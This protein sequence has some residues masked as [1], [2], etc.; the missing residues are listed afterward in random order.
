MGTPVVCSTKWGNLGL[1]ESTT[2]FM[3]IETSGGRGTD[4]AHS[5]AHDGF[6][7]THDGQ[8]QKLPRGPEGAGICRTYDPV[9]PSFYLSTFLPVVYHCRTT[10]VEQTS[11]DETRRPGKP[12]STV[13][14][15]VPRVCQEDLGVSVSE[16]NVVQVER[17]PETTLE[18]P[19][20]RGRT[21]VEKP[22]RRQIGPSPRKEYSSV[23]HG[24]GTETAENF[25]RVRRGCAVVKS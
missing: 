17:T 10:G 16:T 1:K 8:Q 4:K 15:P 13:R 14:H 11:P 18:V 7:R 19:G 3:S 6:L 9:R 25:L 22:S 24:D 20:H 23:F 12:L 2:L 5:K 21:E